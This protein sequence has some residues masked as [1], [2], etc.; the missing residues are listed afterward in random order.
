M[1]GVDEDE[2]VGCDAGDME[3]GG[4]DGGAG[5][6]E[7]GGDDDV[8][9]VAVVGGGGAGEEGEGF[10]DGV[11]EGEEVVEGVEAD[12][13]ALG[14]PAGRGAGAVVGPVGVA[15]AKV[16]GSGGSAGAWGSFV[17]ELDEGGVLVAAGKWGKGGYV[18]LLAPC[19]H[20]QDTSFILNIWDQSII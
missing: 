14:A 20:I 10:V 15:R 13:E 6:V 8:V 5:D 2:A 7:V 17:P 4:L 16:G 18:A 19:T 12:V 9:A 3:D 11:E 1:G